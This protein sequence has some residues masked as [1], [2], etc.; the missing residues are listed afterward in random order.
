MSISDVLSRYTRIPHRNKYRIRCPIHG[1]K[2]DYNF[3]VDED[4]G[5]FNCLSHCGG[6][7]VVTLYAKLENI[8]LIEAAKKL[9]EE[10]HIRSGESITFRSIV[11]EAKQ[12]TA[13]Q[14]QPEIELPPN[15]VLNGYR[16]YSKEAIKH[17]DLRL[18]DRGVLIP[19]TDFQG[20]LVGYSIRQ[21][22]KQ[23]KYLNSTGLRKS[24]LLYGLDRNKNNIASTGFVVLTEGQLDSIR[25]WDYGIK[26]V[27]ASM[28]AGMSTT[29][30]HL[31]APFVSKVVVLYDGDEA[32][33]EAAKKIKESFSTLFQIE[34]K[35][36]PE[37]TDPDTADLGQIF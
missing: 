31:L 1:G 10:Y 19:I 32:G 2:D 14:I 26:N 30:A 22:G 37:G 29:Q 24:E 15:R 11:N 36:L 23:P 25:V 21:I 4:K 28:G 34:I 3:A 9:S 8:S 27:V 33:R 6:G 16:K 20:R 13:P 7:D 5:L 12:W 18:T 17:Y 35:D